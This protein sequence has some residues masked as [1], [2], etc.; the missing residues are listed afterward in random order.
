[1]PKTW[2]EF[3][4]E[5]RA[6]VETALNTLRTNLVTAGVNVGNITVKQITDVKG[7][8]MRYRITVNRAGRSFETYVELT[9]SGVVDEQMAVVITFWTESSNN[10]PIVTTYVSNTP[11]RY[12]ATASFDVCLDRISA[13]E[14]TTRGE[15]LVAARAFLRV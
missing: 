9:A 15:L 14:K 7:M 12:N 13:I 1:M 11:V 5:F 4:L 8:D 3:V 10:P 6:R 2:D